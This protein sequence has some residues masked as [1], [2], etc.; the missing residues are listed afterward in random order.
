MI[1]KNNTNNPRTKNA[2]MKDISSV[3][4]FT[5]EFYN[6]KKLKTHRFKKAASKNPKNAPHSKN[7]K[8][9]FA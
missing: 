3:L 2:A 1:I 6:Y 4:F 8:P 5:L 7:S 9:I